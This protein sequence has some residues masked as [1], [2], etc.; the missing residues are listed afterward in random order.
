MN[1]SNEKPLILPTV[2]RRVWFWPTTHCLDNGFRQLDPKQPCD[3]GVIYVH[4]NGRV[5]VMATDHRGLTV[6]FYDV[7]IMP[8]NH[9]QEG[10]PS[11][12]FAQWMPYQA[13]QAA[14]AQ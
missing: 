12:P 7:E 9:V 10:P 4:P 8:A 13:A 11:A 6:A 1:Q 3:A 2:G 14:K 5:N